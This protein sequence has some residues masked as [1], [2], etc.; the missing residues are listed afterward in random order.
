[1]SQYP[2]LEGR[3]AQVCYRTRVAVI[4]FGDAL[5]SRGAMS[6]VMMYFPLVNYGSDVKPPLPEKHMYIN[7]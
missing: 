4:K 6:S 3:F 2:R 7:K 5:I 1:M